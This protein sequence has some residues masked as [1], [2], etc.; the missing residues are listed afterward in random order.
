MHMK[1]KNLEDIQNWNLVKSVICRYHKVKF[2][3][4]IL[5]SLLLLYQPFITFVQPVKACSW[6]RD[7]TTTLVWLNEDEYLFDDLSNKTRNGVTLHMIKRNVISTNTTY[8]YSTFY[9]LGGD[10]SISPD[11]K[12]LALTAASGNTEGGELVDSKLIIQ[13][14]KNNQT[15]KVFIECN[16]DFE[17]IGWS[18][19]SSVLRV[20]IWL[21]SKP[22][23][24]RDY[25][26]NSWKKTTYHGKIIR[27]EISNF[28][29]KL[30]MDLQNVIMTPLY[31]EDYEE[32][33]LDSTYCNIHGFFIQYPYTGSVCGIA[34]L[35]FT[36]IYIF[37]V[38]FT[39]KSRKNEKS[40]ATNNK[41]SKFNK[42]KNLQLCTLKNEQKRE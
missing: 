12:L 20:K 19:D 38:R 27:N 31:E 39:R 25:N 23:K 16:T 34:I 3:S 29:E 33:H 21:N 13:D 6:F 11:G 28:D 22:Y 24:N 2:I 30:S 9:G 42:D 7:R 32:Y 17:I 36:L 15:M 35:L 10:F 14:F 37:I 40:Q 4:V 18:E 5:L 41:S 1:R 26:T 8:Y